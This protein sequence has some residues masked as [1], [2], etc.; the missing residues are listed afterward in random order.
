VKSTMPLVRRTP[1]RARRKGAAYN[2]LRA[3]VHAREGGSC[4]RCGVRTRPS[5]KATATT[6][7]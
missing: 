2:R 7:C 3:L 5:P 1:L 6:G 4:A